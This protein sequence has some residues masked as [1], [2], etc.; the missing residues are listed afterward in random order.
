MGFEKKFVRTQLALSVSVATAVLGS[1][2]A[3][4]Q[5]EPG[6]THLEDR[7]ESIVITAPFQA[8][9]A[10][11]A[12]PIGILSGEALR[13][14]AANS[15]G[16]TLMNEIGV[17][18]ASFGTGVGQPIIRGQTGNRVSILQNGISLTDA[19]NVS[20]DHVNG[21]EALLADRI[22]VIRGPS[23]LLYGSGAVGGVV[24]VI[25]NRIPSELIDHPHFQLE[26]THNSVNDENKTVMR[27]DGSVGN[28][29]FHLDA[30]TRENNNVEV[31]GFAIDEAAV[32]EIEELAEALIGGMDDHGD[33]HGEEGEPEFDNSNGFINNSDSKG[34]GFTIGGSYVGDS[35]FFGF[36]MA[37]IENE[38][39]LP[40]GS[41]GDHAHGEEEHG[42]ED[43]ADEEE[44]V[45]NVRIGMEQTRYDFKGQYNFS[46]SWI[47]SVKASVGYTDYEH[48]EI[49]IFEDGGFEVGT[50]FSNEGTEARFEFKR[51][52]TGNWEGVWGLQLSDTQFSAIGEEAFIPR[53]DISNIGL[54]GVERYSGD[55]FTAEL[56]VRIEDADVDPD[57]A[58]SN[59]ETALSVSGS[60][61]YDIDDQSNFLVAA[62][63]SERA[64]SIEEL[65]SNIAVADC[66]P[67]ANNEDLVLH[68]ATSLY[69]VGNTQLNKEVSNNIEFGYRRHS[70][71]LTG[72][73]SAYYN[74]IED[75]IFLG[76]TGESVDEQFIATYQAGDATFSG[77][78]AELSLSIYQAKGINGELSFFGDIV[79]AEFDAGG[80]VPRIPPAKIGAEL[81]YFADNWSAHIH[82]T[83]FG[84]QDDA[85]PLELETDGYTL[86][87]AYADYHVPVGGDSEF[88]LFARADNLLNE[89]IRNHASLLR[90]FAPEPGRGITLGLRFEY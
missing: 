40:P 42:D 21:T 69:E 86:V 10:Q 5:D 60:V 78:E 11:T 57:G 15:L 24:N 77:L 50:V 64:P 16:A 28:F 4:G 43:H 49:E 7:L 74:Q 20:P 51:A 59:S 36:S 83:R 61:L 71:R 12:L 72:E 41:H 56:G 9:E 87:S 17:A 26:Q 75:Y 76:L 44:E 33:E 8:T 46:N 3:Y 39:G 2:V 70:G 81:R 45:E 29:G 66:S 19:S 35:G 53:S 38:Y 84:A 73:F 58:C 52:A 37:E 88:K 14:K 22:E 63:R 68:A 18:N 30:F 48:R 65:Y 13:E 90:N 54:F 1:S 25:D 67:V 6:I 89:E 62:A 23:T 79:N 55:S 32:E 31:R 85:G 34:E 82:A 80:N 47:E 27:L